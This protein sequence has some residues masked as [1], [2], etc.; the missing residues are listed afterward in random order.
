MSLTDHPEIIESFEKLG[1]SP[2]EAR[3]YLALMEN[4]PITGYQLSK[5]SGILRPVVYEMLG[6]LVEKGGATIVK[7][8]PDTYSPVEIKVFLKN[9]ESDFTEAKKNISVSLEKALVND[10]SDFFWNLQG[11][12]NIINAAEAMIQS[13]RESIYMRIQDQVLLEELL[14]ALQ[15]RQTEGIHIDLFSY[16][17]LDTQGITLY[18]YNLDSTNPLDS[19]PASFFSLVT[20]T[21]LALMANFTDTKTAKCVQS[22]NP[23]MI[24]TVRQ[25]ILKDIYLIRLWKLMGT[26]KIKILMTNED[27]HLLETID[28]LTRTGH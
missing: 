8:N 18:S 24:Q 23:V 22:R 19:L 25:G 28:R 20:D 26:E 13:A 16:Y 21:D 3:V 1:L 12:K 2:N 17:Q 14:P 11:R 4:H 5:I 6:R 9:I 10:Q 27:R 7:S 15:S